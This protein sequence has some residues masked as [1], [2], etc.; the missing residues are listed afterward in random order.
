V[1]PQL[2]AVLLSAGQD[3]REPLLQKPQQAP[4]VTRAPQLVEF[5]PAVYPPERLA[6]GETADVACAVDIDASG[7]V[8]SVVVEKG[9]APDFD[10]AAVAAIRTFRF[11]PAELDGK[12][13]PVRIRYVYHFV[14]EQRRAERPPEATGTV[15]GEVLEAGTR[16]PLLATVADV[17][18]GAEASTDAAGRYVLRVP[19]GERKLV[20]T[21]VGYERRELTV[22]VTPDATVDVR[23]VSLHRTTVGDLELT[24]EG[25]KVEDAPTRRT[26]HHDELVNVPGALNDP[27]RAV[28]NLPGLNRAPFLGGQ[29]LVRGS[30]PGD[31]GVYVDGHR[32][33]LLY[34]FLGGPSVI[35]EQLVDHID[36]YPGGYGAYYGRNLVGAL[37][38]G[39]ARGAT[40]GLHGEASI[41]LLQAVGFVTAPVGGDTQVSLAARRS[42][43]D[44]FLPLFIPDDPNTGVTTVVPIYWDYQARIDHKDLSLT[45]LGSDDKLTIVQ[46][47]G[48]QTLP[49]SINSHIGFHRGIL[50]W[51]HDFSD[52]FSVRVSPAIGWQVTSF[53]SSGAGPGGFANPQSLDLTQWSGEL[54]AEA[55]YRQSRSVEW[56]AGVDVDYER[57]R[58]EADVQSSL[59]L[60]G[61]G[62]T[63]TQ[64]RVFQR[65]QIGLGIGEYVEATFRIGRLELVPGLRVEEEHWLP[66]QQ[67]V[68][69]DPRL[70]ARYALT[71]ETALKAYAGVYHEPPL[72]QQVDP[73]VGNPRLILERSTQFGVGIEQKLGTGLSVSAEVFY[74]RRSSLI[75][76]ADATVVGGVIENPRL[77]NQG[78]GRAYGLEV[79][80]R[81][82]LTERL[83]GWIAYTLSKSQVLNVPGDPWR[84][85]TY[86][87]PHILTLVA[88]YRPS[89]S[90]NLSARFRYVSGNPYAPIE[91][92]TFDADSGSFV[93]QRGTVGDARSPSF[94]Q[95]DLRAQKTW[96]YDDWELALYLDVQNVLNR[97]NQELQVF[98]YRFREQGSIPGLPIL[99]TF[100][101]KARF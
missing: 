1:I 69:F 59:D 34:H 94:A 96:T 93:A 5:H 50:N 17:S 46:K 3:V 58:Y 45:F 32:V 74:N 6:R 95:L 23:K 89:P 68:A 28:Q 7:A 63:L 99:P 18:S 21:A 41:D 76:R 27:I 91:Y 78:I 19:A 67:R 49:L 54:R 40:D 82:E 48:R 25:E 26:L 101:L 85:F 42:Y 72:G 61:L 51:K 47:G 12:P 88:G 10:E 11:S 15:R 87:Q 55:R 77:L 2:L 53:D 60:Q 20:A 73:D 35:N 30:P 71:D 79:L 86:D 97:R 65:T 100:G 62:S 16:K 31:T 8:T 22:T 33:P 43:I 90:W 24:V 29:L 80:I 56:R 64:Q 57:A 14:I 36:F 84:A 4:Q 39:T 98:D 13:A 83:Y 70:W 92:A 52:A 37:D 81:R 38:V 44:L 9:A 66:A 75:T